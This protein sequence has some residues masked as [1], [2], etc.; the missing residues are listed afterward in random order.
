MKWYAGSDHAGL[1]LKRSLIAELRA[2]GDEVIDL[3]TDGTASVD[4][5]EFGAAV[6]RA[7]VD[8]GVGVRGLVVCGSGIG[9]S[10]AANKIDGVRCALV[11]DTFTAVA[12][13]QH[14]DANVVAMGQ[15]V[16]GL[17]VAIA[18]LRSFRDTEFEGG[19]HQRRVEQLDG[20][21]LQSA[22]GH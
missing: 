15:R 12:A 22:K 18:A 19:R 9:I 17:G 10:I 16:I 11:H 14:N 5:P 7:T 6:G 8:A 1:E 20:L 13:R 3:G 2:W 21:R 4:Y